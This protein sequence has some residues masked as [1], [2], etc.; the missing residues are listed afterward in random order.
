MTA[1]KCRSSLYE[2]PTHRCGD[3]YDIL[4]RR[5]VYS[6]VFEGL[7]LNTKTRDGNSNRSPLKKTGKL[8][9]TLH[10]SQIKAAL[11]VIFR[12]SNTDS[13]LISYFKYPKI[14]LL[15]F[16]IAFL[17]GH[18]IPCEYDPVPFKIG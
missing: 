16:G 14:F 2:I 1:I 3:L 18:G 4:D 6:E 10:L 15:L 11:P 5:V 7:L 8:P 13:Q 9:N 17:V 12:N